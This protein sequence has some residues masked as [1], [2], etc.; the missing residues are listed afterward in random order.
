MH[1]VSAAMR[2]AAGKGDV[3]ITFKRSSGELYTIM[4]RP[5]Q[6]EAMVPGAVPCSCLY[7]EYVVVHFSAK[8]A[9]SAVLLPASCEYICTNTRIYTNKC[10]RIHPYAMASSLVFDSASAGTGSCMF[11]RKYI[12]CALRVND[13]PKLGSPGIQVWTYGNNFE[14]IIII[15]HV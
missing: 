11:M 1:V 12:S 6:A 3:E 14:P 2:A 8:V 15:K 10:K 9:L 7:L 4:A 13:K 5:H